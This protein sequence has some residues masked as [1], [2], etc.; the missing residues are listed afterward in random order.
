MRKLAGEVL[1]RYPRL[2]VLINN[3]GAMYTTRQVTED[4][5]ELT[6]AVNHLAPFLLTTLLLDRLKESAPSRDHH[7]RVG[8]APGRAHPLRRPERRDVLSRLRPLRQTKLANILFTSELARRLKG[9]GV[10]ANCFHPGLGGER[11]QPQ[12]RPADGPWH[13]HALAGVAQPWRR[14]QRPWCGSPRRR[15]RSRP[16]ADTTSTRNGGRRAQR[17]GHADGAAAVGNQ[18]AQ[19]ASP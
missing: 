6:W 18:R 15:R 11:L 19:C 3:A 4:G 5:I 10:T 7:H 1:G 9:S 2:D 17:A 13:D 12:Q 8:G 16:T 14:A